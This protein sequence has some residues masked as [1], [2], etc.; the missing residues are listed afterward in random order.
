MSCRPLRWPLAVAAALLAALHGV[1]SASSTP[2]N[3]YQYCI[4]YFGSVKAKLELPKE[5][6]PEFNYNG[7]IRC[8]TSWDFP[9]IEG[10]TLQLC[11]PFNGLYTDEAKDHIAMDATLSFRGQIA[12]QLNR[13][14]DALRLVN[15]LITNGTVPGPFTKNG[16]PAVLARDDAASNLVTTTWTING[17][18]GAIIDPS[19]R[20]GVYFSCGNL[21]ESQR[22]G[23]Y[24]GVGQ[25]SDG[26][27]FHDLR[28]V[29]NMST[30]MNF[31][32]RFSPSQASVDMTGRNP[33]NRSD[34]ESFATVRFE[35]NTQLPSVVDYDFW[36]NSE[37]VYEVYQSEQNRIRLVPDDNGFPVFQNLTSSGEWYATANQTYKANGGARS[38]AMMNTALLAGVFVAVLMLLGF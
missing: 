21:P 36:R 15:L 25:D 2:L 32:M 29:F 34:F 17:T 7:T 24:C 33:Y 30:P 22:F 1:D 3:Q 6:V 19:T 14:V 18:E 38:V 8:P 27:C 12:Q 4:R 13:P 11:P 35:G 37:S 23:A 31:S 20:P 16:K 9:T 10:A 28:M 5:A 26:G